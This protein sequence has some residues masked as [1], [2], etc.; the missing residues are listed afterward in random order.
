[1]LYVQEKKKQNYFTDDLIEML[2]CFVESL[3]SDLTKKFF[4]KGQFGISM[5]LRILDEP[6]GVEGLSEKF[7][8]KDLQL[9]DLSL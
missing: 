5:K 2:P 8:L 4:G 9:V 3:E 6:G 7:V 1:M